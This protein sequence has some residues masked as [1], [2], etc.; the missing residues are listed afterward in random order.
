MKSYFKTNS[1]STF[2]L[3]FIAF[4]EVLNS[5]SAIMLSKI[6]SFLARSEFNSFN[7]FKTSNFS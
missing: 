3:V 6:E 2:S 7:S 4:N 5:Y 1:Y